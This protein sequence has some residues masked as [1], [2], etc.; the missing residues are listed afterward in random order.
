MNERRVRILRVIARL[1]VGGTALHVTTL[2]AQADSARFQS[3]L[4]TGTENPGEGTLIDMTRAAGIEPIVIP[5]MVGQANF[6]PRDVIAIW[7]LYRLIR[8]LR[9]DVVDT[10]TAKAGFVGRIAAWL[11]RVPVVVHTYHGHVLHGYYGAVRTSILRLMERTLALL[12]TRLIAVSARVRDDL[13]RYGVAPPEKI[14]VIPLGLDLAPFVEHPPPPGEFRRSAG[15][16]DDVPLVGIIGRI[17][18]IKN[19]ALFVEAAARVVQSGVDARFVIVGDGTLRADV[20]QRIARLGMRDR[21]AITG[22][23]R[24]LPAIYR[25]LAL[26]V[27]SSDNEGTPFSIIE[28]MAAGVPV[29]ATRV[30]GI[31]DVVLDGETGVLV[32]P[33]DVEALA[34]AVAAL[35]RDSERRR[36]LG[37]AAR[38]T[39]IARHAAARMVADTTALYLAELARR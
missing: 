31:P 12:S 17:F 18:A 21:I 2:T 24:D 23:R 13:V 37:D 36:T 16:P 15:L 10:H 19:H 34:G 1:N 38:R 11:A 35:L 26:L 7:K 25:D 29:V 33:R 14:S 28:A 30:G 32:P 27:V 6:G 8:Q 22:W 5:E 39:A 20:E 4:V 9:P 3:W